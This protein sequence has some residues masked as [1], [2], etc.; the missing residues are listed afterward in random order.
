MITRENERCR[1]GVR[2]L[3][4][5]DIGVENVIE[6]FNLYEVIVKVLKCI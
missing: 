6:F 2:S 4:E 1:N 5:G 3:E